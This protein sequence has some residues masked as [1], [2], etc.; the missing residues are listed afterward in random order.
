ML[1]AR[2]AGEAPVPGRGARRTRSGG[3][4]YSGRPDVWVRGPEDVAPYGPV[5][6]I[7]TIV[8]LFVWLVIAEVVLTKLMSD[9]E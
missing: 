8:L 4:T 1:A 9:P 3:P 7:E 6:G 2:F 5:M